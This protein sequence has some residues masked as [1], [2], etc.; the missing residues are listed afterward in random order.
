MNQAILD[1]DTL[2]YVLGRRYPEVD[3][4]AHQ[5]LRVFRYFSVSAA[6]I[7][8][9]VRGFS[10]DQNGAATTKFLQGAESYEVF[11]IGV[12]EAAIAGEIM[13]ELERRGLK[14]GREDPFIAATAIANGRV[15]ITNNIKHYQRIVDLGYPLQLD[16]WRQP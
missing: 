10:K 9:V 1:T 6:T 16:N 8:E 12:T 3:A 13:G 7:T 14:I 5:Y 4:T 15:L 2:S 11:P